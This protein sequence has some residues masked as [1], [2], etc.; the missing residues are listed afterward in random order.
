MDSTV[1]TN[2]NGE[3]LKAKGAFL[4]Q[5]PKLDSYIEKRI[6]HFFTKTNQSRLIQD[7]SVHG[8]EKTKLKGDKT[9]CC[10]IREERKCFTCRLLC[11]I[12]INHCV[13]FIIPDIDECSTDTSPCDE[14]AE[15]TNSEGSYSCTCKQGFTGNGTS[16]EGI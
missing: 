3:S 11:L 8:T 5:N 13:F 12:C 4:W 14:N 15:C 2:L 1:L 10:N 9:T 6:L 16:C 7:N